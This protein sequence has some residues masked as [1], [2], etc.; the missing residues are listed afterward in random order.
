M[1]IV[2]DLLIVVGIASQLLLHPV[3]VAQETITLDPSCG[4][5]T[6]NTF[7]RPIDYHTADKELIRRVEEPHFPPHVEN[8]I[9]G[10]TD[11]S[12]GGDISYT[13]R[14]FPN[15]P[16]A[17]LSMSNLGRKEKTDKPRKSSFTIN[18]W[19]QR[20]IS[21]RPEDGMVR[22]VYGIDLMR[23][24]KYKEAVVQ[25]TKAEQLLG[26]NGNLLY[27]IGLAYFEVGEYDKALSYAHKAS[28]MGFNLPG[29]KKKLQAKNRWREPEPLSTPTAKESDKEEIPQLN[30]PSQ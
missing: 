11:D 20:A 27:N 30:T 25:L 12:L 5:L 4:D 24:L 26:T 9:R 22:M 15:H 3:A 23:R 29:L 21:F 28:A 8:L 10:N 18:C 6:E 2:K 16:R 19:F 14:T 17:L 13:L 1:G 7:R